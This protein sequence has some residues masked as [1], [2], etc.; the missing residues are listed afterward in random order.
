MNAASTDD[1]RR[2]VV[3]AVAAS[4]GTTL[5][6]VEGTASLFDLPGFDSVAV[7]AVLE[8]LEAELDL[9]VPAEVVVPDTFR[10]VDALAAVVAAARAAAAAPGGRRP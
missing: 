9:E 3:T 10:S 5:Q 8:W 2:L 4:T 6:V 7:V 1:V